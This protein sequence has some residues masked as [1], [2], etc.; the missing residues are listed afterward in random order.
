MKSALT[1][2]A[3]EA[4]GA[5]VGHSGSRFRLGIATR[6]ALTFIAVAVLAVTANLLVEGQV[7]VMRTTAVVRIPVITRIAAPPAVVRTVEEEEHPAPVITLRPLPNSDPLLRLLERL[8][9][10][11]DAASETNGASAGRYER[12]SAELARQASDYSAG[13]SAAGDP[14]PASFVQSLDSYRQRGASLLQLAQTRHELMGTYGNHFEQLNARVKDALDRA[15]KIF[16]RVVTRQSLVSVSN[17]LDELR[18][19]YTDFSAQQP[20]EALTY[21][22]LEKSEQALSAALVQDRGNYARTDGAGWFA[23]SRTDLDAM[24]AARIRLQRIDQERAEENRKFLDDANRLT[25]TITR[26]ERGHAARQ[27]SIQVAAEAAAREASLRKAAAATLGK[28]P[29]TTPTEA[30]STAAASSATAAPT[31]AVPSSASVPSP[32]ASP[33]LPSSDEQ[34]AETKSTPQATFDDPGN[35]HRRSVIA[36]I[37]ACVLL[38]VVII[39]AGTVMSIVTPVRRLLRASVQIARGNAAARVPRGGV[40]ELDTL[41]LAFN[42]MAEQLAIAQDAARDQQTQLE[43]KV[44]ERTRQLREL[45]EA[46]PLTRLGNRRHFFTMLN[47]AIAQARRTGQIVGVLFI[48]IDNF[49]NMNDSLGHAFGD[50]VLQAIARRLEEVTQPFGIAA[51]LGGD[52]FTV[53]CNRIATVDDIREAG[54]HLVAA[55]HEALACADRDLVISVSVGA[56][57]FPEHA[58]DAESLLRAADAAL[59][60]AKTLGRNQLALFSPELL[61]AARVK[62]TIEQGLRRAM[63]RDEF[64][65]A[66]QPEV[67]LQNYRVEMVEALLRWRT[68]DGRIVLPGDFLPIAEESGLILQIND[69]VLRK[70]I[71]TAARWHHDNWREARVAINVSSRQLF[72]DTFVERVQALLQ[73]HRL[74]PECIEI[75]LTENVLQTGQATIEALR[76]LRA[77]GTAIAL[78]DFGTG[79][80]SLSSLDL[81]PLTRVKLDRSLVSSIDNSPRSAA[82]ARA[83][84]ALCQGLGLTITAEGIER[85]EQLLPLLGYPGL[86]A[87]GFLL[88]QPLSAAAVPQTV[89]ALSSAVETLIRNL[90]AQSSEAELA[91]ALPVLESAARA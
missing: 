60:K 64:E 26:L 27:H 20:A 36:W 2:K 68:P 57:V 83:T 51:R 80:S 71:E 5:L 50:Q 67:N 42:H 53:L 52:E 72:D 90:V 55:F 63:E 85:P 4:F 37:T 40:K 61:E 75:E 15:W 74:P 9:A 32:A 56:S 23:L 13:A 70:A 22:A 11:V 88:S 12:L 16:G 8:N 84:I 35:R 65:L 10:L 28:A 31:V 41:A 14:P 89:H 58:E 45:A 59:F 79:F 86:H 3:Y 30:A 76:R 46:D 25:Q 34:A 62:F 19:T 91:S 38:A 44:L 54:A 21:E 17:S 1:T 18:R 47:S 49:K 77:L 73:Q 24:S 82:I 66:F 69:W 48:D 43:A 6:L 87:Q 81:L 7:S 33:D 39:S 78:D 29:V